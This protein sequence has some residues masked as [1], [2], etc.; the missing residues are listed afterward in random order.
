MTTSKPPDNQPPEDDTALLTAALDHSWAWYDALSN[1][2]FQ[3]INYYLVATAILFT[4]YASAINEKHYGLAVAL[5]LAGLVLTAIA[6]MAGLAEVHVAGQAQPALAKLQER[7]ADRLN[8]NEIRMARFHI[9][10]VGR[11]VAIIIIF[12]LATLVDISALIYAA[13]Q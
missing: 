7:I 10:K 4:A 6:T 11:A 2:A 3:V 5:T 13:I 9:G 1:R 12:G 8:I